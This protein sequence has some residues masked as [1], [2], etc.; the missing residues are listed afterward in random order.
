MFNIKW[1]DQYEMWDLMFPDAVPSDILEFLKEYIKTSLVDTLM[2]E[3]KAFS[4]R[5]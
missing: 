4:H 3:A 2:W 1:H 5:P